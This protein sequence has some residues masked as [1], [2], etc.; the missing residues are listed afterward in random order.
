MSGIN[1]VKQGLPPFS[2]F[3]E[4][5]PD[6]KKDLQ[7]QE[8]PQQLALAQIET[9][10]NLIPSH[11]ATNS[12]P[13][14]LE[15]GSLDHQPYLVRQNSNYVNYVPQYHRSSYD[16]RGDSY[17]TNFQF[18]GPVLAPGPGTYVGQVAPESISANSISGLPPLGV[19]KVSGTPKPPVKKRKLH[20]S[21][22]GEYEWL[23][24]QVMTDLTRLLTTSK[25]LSGGIDSIRNIYDRLLY[26]NTFISPQE[27]LSPGKTLPMKDNRAITIDS[28]KNM[29]T[30]IPISVINNLDFYLQQDYRMLQNIRRAQIFC[31]TEA[32]QEQNEPS[33]QNNRNLLA[34]HPELQAQVSPIYSHHRS[35]PIHLTPYPPQNHYSYHGHAYSYP[36]EGMGQSFPRLQRHSL[37]G[38]VSRPSTSG[39]NRPP[40]TGGHSTS[41][42]VQQP[43][44]GNSKPKPNGSAKKGKFMKFNSQRVKPFSPTECAHCGSTKTP[45]WRRG[46]GGDK[47]LCNAC[48]IFFSKLIKKY[49]GPAEA[50]KIMTQRKEKGEKLDR[51]V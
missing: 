4:N 10:L 34:T 42:S 14:R 38:K 23:P 50:A 13:A 5:I 15:R 27:G 46:P 37:V 20:D 25:D 12:L 16:S 45:E 30:S 2:K 11:S 3:I 39:P 36:T 43:G 28:F 35:Q 9:R 18:P 49:H 24:D 8:T 21:Q 31:L 29:L 17:P 33:Y 6:S 1:I 47:T 41:G 40:S 7:P 32:E 26:E 44:G 19:F 51:H 48:G 22:G